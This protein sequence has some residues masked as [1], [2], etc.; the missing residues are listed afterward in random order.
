MGRFKNTKS[1]ILQKPMMLAATLLLGFSVQAQKSLLF[2]TKSGKWSDAGTWNLQRVPAN[3]DSILIPYGKTVT[4]SES[5]SYYN[6]AIVVTGTL[7]IDESPVSGKT[8]D[9]DITTNSEDIALP[10]VR[11]TRET[12]VVQRGADNVGTGR[13]RIRINN[14]G[15]FITKY[16]TDNLLIRGTA[17]AY[18]NT[19]NSFTL[20]SGSLP[21][22]LVEFT[23]T[24]TD[25]NVYL[26]WK[27]QQENNNEKYVVERSKDA[28]HWQTLS[29][30]PA[31]AN[32]TNP[33]S[34]SFIDNKPL[35]GISYYRLKITDRDGKFGLTP[36]KAARVSGSNSQI[37]LYPNPAIS[38]L[39]VYHNDEQ[40]VGAYTMAI[41]NAS[42]KL[43]TRQRTAAG[44]NI[45]TIDLGY[46]QQGSYTL[47]LVS[48]LGSRECLRF[49]VLK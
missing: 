24:N 43:V 4:F 31:V 16:S 1:A 23:I 36:I 18:N 6:M 15:D 19:S 33:E 20:N 48:D 27:S 10:V 9:L 41:Y 8:I 34:Y 35:K 38:R 45:S 3:N 7:L 22:V 13:L 39:T 25:K 12:S 28:L 46:Y 37:S 32:S 49:V 44:S 42:G 21:V 17:V 47:E 30:V 5:G 29:E 26:K 40:S 14:R 2:A 11:L